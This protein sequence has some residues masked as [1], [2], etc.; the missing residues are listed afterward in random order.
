MPDTTQNQSEFLRRLSTSARRREFEFAVSQWDQNVADDYEAVVDVEHRQRDVVGIIRNEDNEDETS[1]EDAREQ[2]PDIRT[3]NGKNLRRKIVVDPDVRS[4]KRKKEGDDDARTVT[5]T[6]SLSPRPA[7]PHP[8]PD[9]PGQRHTLNFARVIKDV[10]A[11]PEREQA[12][13]YYGTDE[14]PIGETTG[15][16]SPRSN[17]T[18]DD[19]DTP[20]PVLLKERH[21]YIPDQRQLI[22][23]SETQ[24]PGSELDELDRAMPFKIFGWSPSR[25]SSSVPSSTNSTPEKS[26]K[27][28][29]GTKAHPQGIRLTTFSAKLKALRIENITRKLIKKRSDP[30]MNVD[31]TTTSLAQNTRNSIPKLDNEAFQA[32]IMASPISDSGDNPCG[33]ESINTE[34]ERHEVE[35]TSE[36]D[37]APEGPCLDLA[38][39]FAEAYTTDLGVARDELLAGSSPTS[40][41]HTDIDTLAS[42]RKKIQH[43]GAGRSI[44]LLDDHDLARAEEMAARAVIAKYMPPIK[45]IGNFSFG[46]EPPSKEKQ[47]K[48]KALRKNFGHYINDLDATELEKYHTITAWKR[49]W[50]EHLMSP[51]TM[52]IEINQKQDIEAYLD[53]LIESEGDTDNGKAKEFLRLMNRDQIEV[54]QLMAQVD[55]EEIL[56][57]QRHEQRRGQGKGGLTSQQDE[58]P[59]SVP[60]RPWPRL[61]CTP[62]WKPVQKGWVSHDGRI[63]CIEAGAIPKF[64]YRE[65]QDGAEAP[66]APKTIWSGVKGTDDELINEDISFKILGLEDNWKA[67]PTGLYMAGRFDD[68]NN[69]DSG[70]SDIGW[71]SKLLNHRLMLTCNSVNGSNV[72]LSYD[73]EELDIPTMDMNRHFAKMDCTLAN[74]Y[75]SYVK[76]ERKFNRM[77]E[78]VIIPPPLRKDKIPRRSCMKPLGRL[79]R[80]RRGRPVARVE[81][82]AKFKLL[83]EER[84]ATDKL[85]PRPCGWSQKKQFLLRKAFRQNGLFEMLPSVRAQHTRIRG[86]EQYY[87]RFLQQPV[88]TQVRQTVSYG[89]GYILNHITRFKLGLPTSEDGQTRVKI[90]NALK[91]IIEHRKSGQSRY[92]QSTLSGYEYKIFSRVHQRRRV[93]DVDYFLPQDV[94]LVGSLQ[95]RGRAQGTYMVYWRIS[96]KRN[97]D[98]QE[99]GDWVDLSDEGYLDEEHAG[100]EG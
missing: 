73:P 48:L 41:G 74:H 64:A 38:I 56:S 7:T 94:N 31:K 45:K 93:R 25:K 11:T 14:S 36:T 82:W 28:S 99:D 21:V 9:P 71:S 59:D 40:P 54:E 60:D 55:K 89:A 49:N 96:K 12:L 76:T 32:K 44:P 57:K 80:A 39:G 15:I 30:D 79:R 19:Q 90:R 2:T 68:D 27:R 46:E 4:P 66:D 77:G 78:M 72:D 8:K 88:G 37:K 87:P 42:R 63:E 81:K 18:L 16:F 65:E 1:T 84:D 58:G 85:H 95:T 51:G 69:S 17:L 23:T 86:F 75:P 10:T 91:K 92:Q 47:A 35:E 61:P 29:I 43:Y 50:N 83:P 20:S 6:T 52:P 34:V 5:A 13:F 53:R 3:S 70:E 98:R 62:G 100:D 24:G 33:L 97:S 67:S 22:D 26:K